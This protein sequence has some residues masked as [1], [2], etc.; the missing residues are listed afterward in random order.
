M[1]HP[2][3]ARRGLIQV[4]VYVPPPRGPGG[5]LKPQKFDWTPANLRHAHALFE[6]GDRTDWVREGERVYQRRQKRRQRSRMSRE[7][8]LWCERNAVTHSWSYAESRARV[9]NNY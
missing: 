1:E 9:A 4:P 2:V 6:A 3:F 7:D 8:R 5:R